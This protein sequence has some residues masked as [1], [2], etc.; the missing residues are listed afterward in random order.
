VSAAPEGFH[1]PPPQPW[2]PSPGPPAA[3][4][5]GLVPNQPPQPPPHA[6]V[7]WSPPPEAQH[8]GAQSAPSMHAAS[9]ATMSSSTAAA[10]TT[11]H[12]MTA[13]A[14]SH[15]TSN[16]NY[17]PTAAAADAAVGVPAELSCAAPGGPQPATSH[18]PANLQASNNA[19]GGQGANGEIVGVARGGLCSASLQGQVQWGRLRQCQMHAP[20]W[21]WLQGTQLA[22]TR[23]RLLL[24][25]LRHQAHLCR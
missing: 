11:H 3:P 1:P 12:S 13:S 9:A 19:T 6:S 4:P 25:W 20:S 23:L 24:V 14:A 7:H 8:V 21:W 22:T 5:T 2:T 18:S 15:T 10:T 17:L 16:H